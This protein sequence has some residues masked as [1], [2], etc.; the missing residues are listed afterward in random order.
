MMSREDVFSFKMGGSKREPDTICGFFIHRSHSIL[1]PFL[2]RI[3]RYNLCKENHEE[4]P[5]ALLSSIVSRLSGKRRFLCWPERRGPLSFIFVAVAV[6][7]HIQ[8]I[9]CFQVQ[10]G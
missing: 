7:S 9:P 2:V 3:R 4:S 1:M 10:D 6:V 5:R 8:S